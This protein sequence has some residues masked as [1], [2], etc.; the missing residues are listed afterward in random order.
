MFAGLSPRS[1]YL[2]FHAPLGTLPAAHRRALADVDHHDHIALVAVECHPLGIA[3]LIRT[4]PAE[5]EVSVAVVDTAH[6]RG[7]ARRLLAE[8]DRHAVAAG[9]RELHANVL[10]ENSAALALFR[11]S[12]AQGPCVVEGDVLRLTCLPGRR[13]R[14][15]GRP[16]RPG[17]P[18]RRRRGRRR[19]APAA[20]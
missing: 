10:A 13:T 12:F 5:A 18:G 1:R 3:R 16:G 15:A 8:L 14:W 11:A 2:R 19:A 4:G 20:G 9:V 6:R 17:A 7:V